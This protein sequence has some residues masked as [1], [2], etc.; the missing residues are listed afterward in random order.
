[1]LAGLPECDINKMQRIENVAA[2]L[3]TK[4]KKH[5]STMT[6]L[7]KLH[8]LP[9]RARIEHK[10]L[11]LVYKCLQGNAPQY[12]KKLIVEAQ[13]RR[14]GLQSSSEYIC[15]HVPRT[16]GK[17][18]AARSFSIKGPKLWNRISPA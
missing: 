6:M 1:M 5:D 9:I 12:L 10:L 13:P 4:V 18:L 11:T 17:T 15:L 2:K 7:R 16:K 3:A 8:W 14:D